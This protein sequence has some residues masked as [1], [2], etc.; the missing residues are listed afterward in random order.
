MSKGLSF[1]EYQVL[2]SIRGQYEAFGGWVFLSNGMYL[3]A[4]N[5]LLERSLIALRYT[6]DDIA[7]IAPTAQGMAE[8]QRAAIVFNGGQPA[9]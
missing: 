7:Q 5:H 8:L 3:R 9:I 4:I 6:E 2:A 1:Q